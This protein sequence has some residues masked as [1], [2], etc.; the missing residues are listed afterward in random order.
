MKVSTSRLRLR[1]VEAL[2]LPWREAAQSQAPPR[3]WIQ[4]IREALGMSAA[5]LGRR[6]QVTRQ[7]VSAIERGEARKTVS[8]ATMQRVAAAM[9]CELV[10]ALVP[11]RSLA[12]MRR[13]QARKKAERT[14]SRVAHSMRLEAQD[15][16]AE[17]YEYQ[18]AE[19]AERYVRESPRSLWND[20]A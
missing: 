3:S 15:L 18:V 2:T 17:E 1:Q 12:E 14:L 10:Y 11:L 7:T 4:T 9:D 20:E 8:L 6:L 16:R 19:L 5:Q 13:L